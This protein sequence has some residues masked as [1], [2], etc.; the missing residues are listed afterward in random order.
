MMRKDGARF[1]AAGITTG[2]RNTEGE[3]LGFMKVMRDQTEQKKLETELRLV[4]AELAEANRRKDEF[5]A[6]LAHE[7]RNPLAPIRA[8]LDVM[9][10]HNGDASVLDEARGVIERQTDQLVM[11]V[12][13]L[14]DVSRITRGVFQ[15]RRRRVDLAT[16]V[17]SA[18]EA[19]RPFIDE[20]GHHLELDISKQQIDLDADPNRLAQVL[21]NLIVNATKYTPPGGTI[22][23]AARQER[24]EAVVTVRDNGT[25]I[26]AE[27]LAYIFEM[28]AQIER[29]EPDY[30]GLGIG[31]TIAKRLVELHDG[32]LTVRSEGPGKGSEFTVHLPVVDGEFAKETAQTGEEDTSRARPLRVLVVDDNVSAA[33]MLGKLLGT[34]GHEIQTAHDGTE[35]IQIAGDFLPEV[36]LMD[37]G[38]PSMNGYDAARHIRQQPWGEAMKLVALT[39]W[40]QDEDRKRSKDAGFD[41]HLVK[42]AQMEALRKLLAECNRQG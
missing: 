42:P 34:M 8:G 17:S 20:R 7:L 39:G 33:R 40:G 36:I 27:K 1:W 12:D 16:I 9:K 31:L 35:A 5:L 22:W 23:L 6:T 15:L 14:L 11:L 21:T 29:Q 26:P 28:F 41:Y 25:G 3:L 38:M 32:Q 18:I 13:D 30:L 4:A 24:R 19:A 2:L 37:I 10:R